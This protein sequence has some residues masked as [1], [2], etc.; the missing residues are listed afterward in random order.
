LRNQKVTKEIIIKILKEKVRIKV[1]N[2]ILILQEAKSRNLNIS[3]FFVKE[4]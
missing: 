3:A 4:V 2:N 1:K